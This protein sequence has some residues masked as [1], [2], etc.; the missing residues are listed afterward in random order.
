MG[1]YLNPGAGEATPGGAGEPNLDDMNLDDL[2]LGGG[3]EPEG[4]LGEGGEPPEITVEI[5]GEQVP[6]SEIKRWRDTRTNLES[7]YTKKF[8]TLAEQRKQV[9]PLMNWFRSNPRQAQVIAAVVDGQITPQQALQYLT[10]HAGPGHQATP[11][12]QVPPEV[13]Q[14]IDGLRQ[15]VAWL[16]S[17]TTSQLQAQADQQITATMA[18]LAERAKADGLEWTRE[19]EQEILETA[20][21]NNVSNLEL[22]YNALATQKLKAQI[23]EAKKQGELETLQRLK[24][25]RQKAGGILGG[26]QRGGAAPAKDIKS[27]K[28]ATDAALADEALLN[29]LITE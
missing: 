24:Q 1:D 17:A 18:N 10:R 12:G 22:V 11:T 13:A 7:A 3:G 15:E 8:Q 16:K 4:A 27:Y 25:N 26:Q 21:Q 14:V 20:L 9:E 2:G 28:D 6:L 23:A 19:L 29:S 5:D